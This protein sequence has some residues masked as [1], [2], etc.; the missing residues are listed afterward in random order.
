[1]A[2]AHFWPS[3]DD[4][5]HTGGT[6]VTDAPQL[7]GYIGCRPSTSTY[8]VAYLHDGFTTFFAG[9]GITYGLTACVH[10]EALTHADSITKPRGFLWARVPPTDGQVKVV[11]QMFQTPFMTGVNLLQNQAAQFEAWLELSVLYRVQGGTLSGSGTFELS[12]DTVTCYQ[13]ALRVFSGKLTIRV[14][15]IVAGVIST[16]ASHQFELINNL[17][18]L[19]SEIGLRLKIQDASGNPELQCW[20]GPFTLTTGQVFAEYPLF[21]N[22]F[23]QFETISPLPGQ[24]IAGVTNSSAVPGKLIDANAA[25]ITG[26]GLAGFTMARERRVTVTQSFTPT[27]VAD[28]VRRFELTSVGGTVSLS[29]HFERA[30]GL[31]AQ[32]VSSNF[33]AGRSVQQ[34]WAYDSYAS[35]SFP[36][37]FDWL[38]AGAKGLIALGASGTHSRVLTYQRRATDPQNQHRQVQIRLVASGADPS[39]QKAGIFLRG[40]P[41]GGAGNVRAYFA[42]AFRIWLGGDQRLVYLLRM[43]SSTG[44]GVP[45]SGTLIASKAVTA[46]EIP[47]G[48]DFVLDAQCYTHDNALSSDGPVVLKVSI[49]G[50]QIALDATAAA[51][52][53]GISSDAAGTVIDFSASRITGGDL[54]GLYIESDGAWRDFRLDDWVQGA[55]HAGKTPPQ[56]QVTVAVAGE[57]AAVGSLNTVVVPSAVFVEAA[58]RDVLSHPFESGHRQTFPRQ[59]RKRRQFTVSVDAMTDTAFAALESFFDDHDGLEIPFNFTLPAQLGVPSETVAVSFLEEDLSYQRRAP[60]VYV[61]VEFALEEVIA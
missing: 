12:Y 33:V 29:D 14:N 42:L 34:A 60:G 43:T 37:D 31:L 2:S 22:V 49:D 41:A 51:E 36:K 9:Q 21:A 57:G 4:F 7:A 23:P 13:V 56:N 19:A 8:K 55:L 3:G 30:D 59:Q 46:T 40:T 26:A 11:G 45:A 38:P 47:V 50:V 52:A 6:Q 54:E 48:T 58:Q 39:Y 24:T 20:L 1:M 15:R 35:T 28:A 61:G 32:A 16:I 17:F 53:D 18:S 5:G 27:D 44:D 25:K 10:S